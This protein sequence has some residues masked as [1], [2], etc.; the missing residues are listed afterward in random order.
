MNLHRNPG[1]FFV[2]QLRS[3]AQMGLGFA[4]RNY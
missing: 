1:S 2:D 3:A 4:T